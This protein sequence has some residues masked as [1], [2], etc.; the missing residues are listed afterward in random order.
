MRWMLLININMQSNYL[1]C[2]SHSARKFEFENLLAGDN[3]KLFDCRGD[4]AASVATSTSVRHTHL[5]F[6]RDL[7]E[8]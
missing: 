8:G 2:R 1:P 4:Q 3:H 5:D 7:P 6:R